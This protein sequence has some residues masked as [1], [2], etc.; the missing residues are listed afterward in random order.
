MPILEEMKNIVVLFADSLRIF[1]LVSNRMCSFEKSLAWGCKV[2]ECAKI[3]VFTDEKIAARCR[4]FFSTP[5]ITEKAEI[6]TRPSWNVFEL[7]TCMHECCTKSACRN[8]VYAWADCPFLNE[9]LTLEM[10][11]THEKY[12]AE[13]TFAD[14]YPYGFAPE[15]INCGTASIIAALSVKEG[16]PHK[17]GTERVSRESIFT[18]M[19][20]DINAFEIETV[21][22]PVDWRMYRLNFSVGKKENFLACKKLAEISSSDDSASQLSEK[23]VKCAGILRTVPGFYNIQIEKKVRGKCLYNPYFEILEQNAELQE[24]LVSMP[25]E[26][27]SSLVKQIAE[28]SETAVISLS[29]WGEP[30]YHP[31]LPQFISEVLKY[32]GLSVFIE[33]SGDSLTEEKACEI[34]KI[35]DSCAPRSNGWQPVMWIVFT[36]AVTAEK[37]SE[38]HFT[39]GFASALNSISILEKHFKGC[40]YPQFVRMNENEEQLESFYRFWSR[41]ESPSG[42]A[43]IIQKY[44]DFAGF[45]PK[46][47]PCDLSPVER[48]LDWH[49]RR[50]M[51]ILCTGDVMPYKESLFDGSIGNVFEENLESIW[52][53]GDSLMEGQLAGKYDE[54]SGKYDEYYTFNF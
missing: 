32:P 53:K 46:R 41:K 17:I 11:E 44:N 10:L 28:F 13:Y 42:G 38:I 43:L 5:E 39:N 3:F 27:F 45:L 51:V 24:K 22:S 4:C 1:D 49:L 30:L 15:I 12:L 7:L 52:R 31:Q 8:I 36:D 50:D 19:K 35:V 6:I 25:F 14:G 40:V 26:K 16:L 18:A 37:Y 33:T 48:C 54:I 9:K 20:G 21:I 23:A 29:L 34:A 2:P 47:S